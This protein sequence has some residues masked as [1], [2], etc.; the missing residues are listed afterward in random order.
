MYEAHRQWRVSNPRL[1]LRARALAPFLPVGGGR[2]RCRAR[3]PIAH[4][5]FGDA[6]GGCSGRAGGRE[7]RVL[8][9][10][11]GGGACVRGGGG[12][13]GEFPGRFAPPMR[14]A[15]AYSLELVMD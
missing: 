3:S 9:G 1:S 13:W 15:Q 5:G 10:G 11:G 4:S 7:T 8:G 6:G 14:V 12:G 2:R